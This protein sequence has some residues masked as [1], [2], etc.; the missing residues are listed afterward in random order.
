MK[1]IIQL[2]YN[3]LGIDTLVEIECTGCG[4]KYKVDRKYNKDTK[5]NNFCNAQCAIS[6]LSKNSEL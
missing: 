6:Y 4:I 2:I 1:Y 5:S 3:L